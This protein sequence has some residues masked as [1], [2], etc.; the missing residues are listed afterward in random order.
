MKIHFL[1]ITIQCKGTDDFRSFL[2]WADSETMKLYQLRGYG[3][4]PG[5]A[6]DNAWSKYVDDRNSYIEHEEDWT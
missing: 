5:E 3:S 4:T 2:N 1:N 6:A